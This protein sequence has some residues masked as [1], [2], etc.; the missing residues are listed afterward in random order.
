MGLARYCCCRVW[1]TRACSPTS[2]CFGSL[3]EVPV[4]LTVFHYTLGLSLQC[5]H[6]LALFYGFSFVLMSAGASFLGHCLA[7]R[8]LH[9]LV[10]PNLSHGFLLRCLL[11][12]L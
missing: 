6:D 7:S 5:L 9:G 4:P 10:I 2:C 11:I 12:P 8:F 1:T 3:V